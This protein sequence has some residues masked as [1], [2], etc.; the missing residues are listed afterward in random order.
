MMNEKDLFN[1]PR[2]PH[3]RHY[4]VL[5]AFYVDGLSAK[6][7]AE[8][9]GYAL[10]TFYAIKRTFE[11]RGLSILFAESQPGPKHAPKKNACIKRVIELRKLNYS[12]YDIQAQLKQEGYSLSHTKISE[13]LT[14][15]GFAKLRRRTQQE[16]SAKKNPK[17]INASPSYVLTF[18]LKEREFSTDCGG[19]FLFLPLLCELVLPEMIAAA[20]YPGTEQIPALNYFLSF[21]ALK[22]LD[23]ERLSHVDDFSFDEGAGLF[24]GL[25]VLPKSAAL[26]SYS[27]SVTRNMNLKFLAK[28]VE[29]LLPDDLLPF[30]FFNLDFHSVPHFGDESVLENHWVPTRN[31]AMKSALTFFVQDAQSRVF[32]YA[33]ADLKRD[34]KSDEILA[35]VDFW[36]KT[37]GVPPKY[38]IFD[39]KLTTYQ[40]LNVLN[41]RGILFLTIRKRGKKMLAEMSAVPEEKWKSVRL[42]AQRRRYK[43]PKVYESTISL[44]DYD[45]EVRQLVAKNLGR[46]SPTFLLTN[47]F[48]STKADLLLRY[49][50]RT[51]IENDLDSAIAFFH[52]NRLSSSI[53]VKVDFDVKRSLRP[54]GT[55]TLLA[56]TLYRR[57][58]QRLRGFETC[59]AKQLFRKFASTRANITVTAEVVTVRFPKR[60][61]NPVLSHAAL[62]SEMPM[63][64]WLKNKVIRFEFS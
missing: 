41:Q 14:E 48:E 22:L 24:A 5:R 11:Q 62:D 53:W 8:K 4:E 17:R 36:T 47:D 44:S 64:P 49:A 43:R 3:Q 31:K 51:L 54:F 18:E 20:E 61:H 12:I 15:Q 63:I 52:L 42:D 59:D 45:G 21:L 19:L 9:F 46:E 25:N 28:L 55:T 56:H 29:K 32:C 57:L 39:S 16:K 38:L 2:N 7:A 27:Y 37:A 10:S 50:H 26:S 6:E 40:N 34:E 30:E 35:F 1:H 33:N 23:K 13:I 60:A 58:A